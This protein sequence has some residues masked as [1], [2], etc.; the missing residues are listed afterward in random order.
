MNVNRIAYRKAT[1]QDVVFMSEILVDAA[2]ASGVHIL[3]DDLFL[4]PDTYQYIENFPEGLDVGII[5]ETTGGIPLGAAW[6]R[7]LPDDVHAVNQ[8]MPELTMGVVPEY[9]RMGVGEQLMEELY[10]AAFTMGIPEISLGVHKE[11]FPA[12]N[13]YKKQGWVEDGR[14]KDYIMM[15]RKTN[16]NIRIG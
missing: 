13:L 7:M 2:K 16:I 10:N 14:F 8:P 9:R 6:V 12:I 4:H 1:K 15:S 3:I 5:A 11:N